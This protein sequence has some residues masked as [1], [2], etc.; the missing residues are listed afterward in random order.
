MTLNECFYVQAQ[1][2]TR[3]ASPVINGDVNPLL[4][5][6]TRLSRNI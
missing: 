2:L 4:V 5:K 1:F 3:R 6:Y